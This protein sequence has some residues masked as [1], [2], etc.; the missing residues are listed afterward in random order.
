[1]AHDIL[2]TCETDLSSVKME[3][4]VDFRLTDYVNSQPMINYLCKLEK[5]CSRSYIKLKYRLL[6]KEK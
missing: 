4:L 5:F 2:F 3:C 6:V 1:M